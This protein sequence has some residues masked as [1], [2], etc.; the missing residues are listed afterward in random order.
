MG[1]VWIRYDRTD[2]S[3]NRNLSVDNPS[4]FSLREKCPNTEFFLV[5]I[6][7]YLDQKK[8]LIWTLFTQRSIFASFCF[9]YLTPGIQ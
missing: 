3:A 1:E 4:V 5:S 2:I 8:L 6:F 9:N 7:P